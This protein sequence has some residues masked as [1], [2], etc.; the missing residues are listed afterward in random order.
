MSDIKLPPRPSPLHASVRSR[1]LV[2]RS[3]D[4]GRL[5][6]SSNGA[7]TKPKAADVVRKAAAAIVNSGHNST[8]NAPGRRRTAGVDGSRLAP[9]VD[10]EAGWLNG[11]D[12]ARTVEAALVE[13]Q[14]SDH[15]GYQGPRWV[16]GRLR[17]PCQSPE[18]A[19]VALGDVIYRLRRTGGDSPWA[20]SLANLLEQNPRAPTLASPVYARAFQR[21]WVGAVDFA[22]D[23][24]LGND[25]S[26]VSAVY[27]SAGAWMRRLQP[28]PFAVL[29]GQLKKALEAAGIT[30]ALG[31]YDLSANKDEDDYFEPPYR[32]QAWFLVRTS[33]I[34]AGDQ[35]FR[36]Y[37]PKSDQ[38]PRPVYVKRWDGRLNALAYATK[39]NFMRRVTV[40]REH[41]QGWRRSV[42]WRPLRADQALEVTFML[43]RLR[44]TDRLIFRG[45]RFTRQSNGG[46][47]I[48]RSW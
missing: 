17:K 30:R 27:H 23:D 2:E 42:Q 26:L 21:A 16:E 3:K 1:A 18:D 11:L 5:T 43:N 38:V 46:L 31:G 48:A 9:T 40:K 29:D 39:P 8:A 34:K 22:V 24:L 28:D 19:A 33:E 45:V 44:P 13:D 35:V 14:H 37:F 6:R 7:A 47:I 15:F 12:Y 41:E 4:S 10:A 32:P 20:M 25:V 36:K